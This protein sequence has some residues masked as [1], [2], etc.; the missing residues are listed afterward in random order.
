MLVIVSLIISLALDS[1]ITSLVRFTYNRILAILLSYLILLICML[2][3]IVLVVPL[4][5]GELTQIATMV[6]TSF[7]HMK[8]DLQVLGI[9]WYIESFDRIPSYMQNI[10]FQVLED[11]T[12]A[13]QLQWILTQNISDIVTISSSYITNIWSFAVWFI[14]N[15]MTM[16][17]QIGLCLIL[18]IF[19][20]LE[21][22][23]LI[24]FVSSLFPNRHHIYITQKI[25]RL[26]A[27][28]WLWLKGQFV[29]CVIMT[30]VVACFLWTL[31]LFGF[32]LNHIF[33]LALIA[34]FT[35]F[36][37]YVWPLLGA[38]PAVLIA[39][40][41]FGRKGF[42]IV[43]FWYFCIQRL[44]NN[45][46][47]PIIMKKAIGINPLLIFLSM[48]CAGVMMWLVWVIL[49]VPIAQVITIIYHDYLTYRNRNDISLDH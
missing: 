24:D 5:I 3:G 48:I 8:I 37:P 10:F 21:K 30:M 41:M 25:N 14:S 26:Y 20:S 22:D 46:L 39:T 1:L 32:N 31:T 38:I 13:S 36:I 6:I 19:F 2:M 47:I 7:D 49:A 35:E 27:T 17:F 4:V 18:A 23:I 33:S 12:I 16:M 29:L 43:W 45:I 44:E 42:L 40:M 34:W 11:N 9:R 15:F 28:M